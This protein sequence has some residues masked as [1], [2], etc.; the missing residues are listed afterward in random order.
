M[1][2]A[3]LWMGARLYIYCGHGVKR[4]RTRR[5]VHLHER[6]INQDHEQCNTKCKV[7]LVGKNGLQHGEDALTE[8]KTHCAPSVAHI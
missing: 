7:N 8:E 3:Q 5:T 6:R 1:F 2:V 4:V